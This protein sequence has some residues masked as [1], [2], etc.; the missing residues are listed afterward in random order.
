MCLSK[1]LWTDTVYIFKGMGVR[2]GIII[3]IIKYM[4]VS[5][6]ISIFKISHF[7]MYYQLTHV[8]M[9]RP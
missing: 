8:I 7:I 6:Y 2:G 4:I 5:M 1:Y 3:Y 9:W